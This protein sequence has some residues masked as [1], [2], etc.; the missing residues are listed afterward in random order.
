MDSAFIRLNQV[1]ERELVNGLNAKMIHFEKLTVAHVKIDK[2]AELPQ[3]RHPHE[4]IT[5]VIS[6]E[7]KMTLG[8]NTFHCHAGD[9]LMIPSDIPHSAFAVTDCYVI[10]VFHPVR[11]D[12]R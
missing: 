7:L 8:D 11:D 5:N 6:G 2:G 1:K 9:V 4:Q 12:Y 10:D 3:H